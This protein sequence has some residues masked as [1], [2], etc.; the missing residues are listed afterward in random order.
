MGQEAADENSMLGRMNRL[1]EYMIANKMRVDHNHVKAE[2]NAMLATEFHDEQ[3]DRLTKVVFN[4]IRGEVIKVFMEEGKIDQDARRVIENL[5]WIS[6]QSLLMFS[7]DKEIVERIEQ[8]IA[9]LTDEKRYTAEIEKVL[10]MIRTQLAKE[11]NLN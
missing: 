1:R 8:S 5:K 6:N 3:I 11:V 4:R 10:Q 2:V 9:L 7:H